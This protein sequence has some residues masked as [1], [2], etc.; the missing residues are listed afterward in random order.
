MNGRACKIAGF[1]ES[2]AP[3]DVPRIGDWYTP[4]A[5]FRDPF[6][7]VV[8]LPAIQAVYRHMFE[9]LES[10]RFRVL[11]TVAEGGDCWLTWDMS[12]GAGESRR[13]IHGASFLQL[14]PDGRI[15]LHRDYWDAAGELYEKLPLLGSILRLVRRRLAAPQR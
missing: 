2:F 1:F 7:D 11:S 9:Q 13:N 8:G 4:E 10:P 15:S 3:E 12:Y 5:V 6:N 14:A